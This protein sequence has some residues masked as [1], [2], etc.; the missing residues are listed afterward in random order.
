M[1]L[2]EKKPISHKKSV[3]YIG[4]IA[5]AMRRETNMLY[6]PCHAESALLMLQV[7]STQ[8][9][10]SMMRFIQYSEKKNRTLEAYATS[11]QQQQSM[12]MITCEETSCFHE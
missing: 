8:T 2:I 10:R 9:I 4:S 12:G 3:V 6:V 7:C 11:T 1:I 5:A